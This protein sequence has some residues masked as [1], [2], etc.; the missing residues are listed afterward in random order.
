M[1]REVLEIEQTSTV[2]FDR[3]N[4]IMNQPYWEEWLNAS[5]EEF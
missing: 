4:E 1:Q 3:E 5:W 2:I